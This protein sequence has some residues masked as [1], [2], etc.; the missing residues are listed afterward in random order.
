[1]IE[2][3]TYSLVY[4]LEILSCM[5]FRFRFA[6]K[7]SIVCEYFPGPLRIHAANF[8]DEFFMDI[9]WFHYLANLHEYW[10]ERLHRSPIFALQRY[11]SIFLVAAL[12]II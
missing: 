9:S 11:R 2:G 3:D 8:P 5:K 7:F 6:G 10:I 12:H 1:M 4:I